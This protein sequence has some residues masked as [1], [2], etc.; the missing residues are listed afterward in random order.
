MTG[1]AEWFGKHMLA[2]PEDAVNPK[3]LVL[4]VGDAPSNGFGISRREA[5]RWLAP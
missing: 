1:G 3:L 5:K 2:K 4:L